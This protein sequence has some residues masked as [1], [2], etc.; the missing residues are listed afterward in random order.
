MTRGFQAIAISVLLTAPVVAAQAPSD[1]GQPARAPAALAPVERA[2][3]LAVNS[4][5]QT[6]VQQV[7]QV[8]PQPG[9]MLSGAPDVTGF[10]LTGY[11]VFFHV[12]V[13]AIRP[14]FAL[15]LRLMDPRDRAPQVSRG[16]GTRVAVVNG[17]PDTAVVEPPPPPDPF[18]DPDLI[19]DPD[20]VYTREVKAQVI[21]A[22]LESSRGLGLAPDEVLTVAA[23]DN[24]PL[25]LL[26]PIGHEA[27]TIEFKITGRDLAAY[28]SGAISVDEARKR[29][30]VTE[31]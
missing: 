19:R 12:R 26:D 18:V 30:A 8:A 20:A 10:R 22:M 16:R 6:V 4:G 3:L 17:A 2:L 28:H 23:R 13:P 15:A 9:Y 1:R 31:Q 5:A 27:Q 21:E 25:D 7:R 29:V 11:G 24:T 14:T